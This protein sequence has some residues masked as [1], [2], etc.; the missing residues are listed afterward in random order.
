MPVMT[1]G[2]FSPGV[3]FSMLR[4]RWLGGFAP[5]FV[6]RMS[7]RVLVMLSALMIHSIHR[8]LWPDIA[9]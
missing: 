1:G 3:V 5:A 9:P 7:G 2:G 8:S 6:R 4:E